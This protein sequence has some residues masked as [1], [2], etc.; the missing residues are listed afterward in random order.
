MVFYY[1]GET[2]KKINIVSSNEEFNDIIN[3]G[4]RNISKFFYI[5]IKNNDLDY[6]RYGIAIS[7]KIGNAVVR[8]KFKRQIKDIID[9]LNLNNESKDYIFIAKTIINIKKYSEI[10]EDIFSFMFK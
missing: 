2:M 8:N 7:K 4:K 5:Y 10:R 9:D 3:S 1:W 6:N